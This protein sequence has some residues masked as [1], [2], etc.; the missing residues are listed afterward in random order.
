MPKLA[1]C[2]Q[3]AD[4]SQCAPNFGIPQAAKGN[5]LALKELPIALF[6]EEAREKQA[7]GEPMP[8]YDE[9]LR[10]LIRERG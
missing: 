4:F 6:I 3:I 7:R 5:P 8:D 9:R 10:K 2:L 1:S